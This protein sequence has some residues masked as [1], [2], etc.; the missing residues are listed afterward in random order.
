MAT[1][2]DLKKKFPSGK[3][4]NRSDKNKNNQN[5]YTSTECPSHAST[6]TCNAFNPSGT[7]LSWQC[8]GFAEKCGYDATGYNP[9]VDDNGWSTST[10]SSDVDRVKAGDIVR[11]KNGTYGNHSIYV[12]G[13]SGDT[14]TYG[15]C[16]GTSKRCKI[17]WDAT[18][19][20]KTLK[21]NLVHIRKAPNTLS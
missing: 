13:V 17:R 16:N 6:D 15:D 19:T 10:T 3:F 1:L 5:G 2:A 18:I 11:F 21:D 8:M 7:N 20:K 14:V 9:R 4:W 12:T